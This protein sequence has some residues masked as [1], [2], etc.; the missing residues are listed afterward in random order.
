M[1]GAYEQRGL[2]GSRA[3]CTGLTN[4][5]SRWSRS[6]GCCGF[7]GVFWVGRIFSSFFFF[8][9]FFFNRTRRAASM[10]PPCLIYLSTSIAHNA[11]LLVHDSTPFTP[12]SFFEFTMTVANSLAARLAVSAT[13]EEDASVLAPHRSTYSYL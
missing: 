10:R 12:T 3:G 5:V 6:P 1:H 7:R 2:P 11:V 13:T 4:K 8:D 9:L